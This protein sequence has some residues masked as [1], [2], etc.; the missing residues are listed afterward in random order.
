[1]GRILLASGMA[2]LALTGSA[3]AQAPRPDL[4]VTSVAQPPAAV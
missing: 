3:L 1:M 2:A 4:T